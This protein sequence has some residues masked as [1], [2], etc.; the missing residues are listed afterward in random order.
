MMV[1]HVLALALALSV[2]SLSRSQAEDQPPSG[3]PDMLALY[4]TRIDAQSLR[5]VF[6]AQKK[7]YTLH[8]TPQTIFCNY[9]RREKSWEYLKEHMGKDKHV[10]TVK[11]DPEHKVA[12]VIWN[13]GPSMV[14][15]G[16][17]LLDASTHLDF[18]ALCVKP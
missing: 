5:L 4:L 16:T 17:S 12:L 8:L 15:Q 10:I 7:T 11:T 13:T 3:P 6:P 2:L 9:G 18:P 14:S 1:K